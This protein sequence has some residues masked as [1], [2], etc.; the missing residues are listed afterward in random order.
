MPKKLLLL[1][2][3]VILVLLLL[4][5]WCM[6]FRSGGESLAYCDNTEQSLSRP[7]DDVSK[8]WVLAYDP[9]CVRSGD[10]TGFCVHHPSELIVDLRGLEGLP[11]PLEGSRLAEGRLAFDPDDDAFGLALF[12]LPV[13]VDPIAVSRALAALRVPASPNYQ[14]F[15]SPGHM[16]FPGT[17]PEGAKEAFGT[18]PGAFDPSIPPIHVLDTGVEPDALQAAPALIEIEDDSLVTNGD[19]ELIGGHGGFVAGIIARQVEGVGVYVWAVNPVGSP[20]F[21]E[22]DLVLAIKR[23]RAAHDLDHRT[24]PMLTNLSL[25]IRTCRHGAGADDN[26]VP[27]LSSHAVAD[28]LLNGPGDLVVAAVGN[29][30]SDDEVAYPA[31]LGTAASGSAASSWEVVGRRVLAI[32]AADGEEIASYSTRGSW[33]E[34]YEEGCHDSDFPDG[35]LQVDLALMASV[36]GV[37]ESDVGDYIPVTEFVGQAA[38]WCGSSFATPMVTAQIAELVIDNQ[39]ATYEDAWAKLSPGLQKP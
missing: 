32:G 36:L 30:G 11:R 22:S 8:F 25:G 10:D 24:E 3:A 14:V 35:R 26:P 28:H 20:R 21:Y 38:H 18:N 7:D 4:L 23:A 31:A 1:L 6:W 15:P 16:F 29:S 37:S 2:L 19:I 9:E 13:G 17:M 5:I 27:L 34:G 39:A 33:V 12:E